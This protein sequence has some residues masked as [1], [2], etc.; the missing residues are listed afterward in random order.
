MAENPSE[1]TATRPKDF[2]EIY[3]NQI[4]YESSVW[5]LKILFS[6]LDQS[7]PAAVTRTRAA[8]T[9]PWAQVKLMLYF[10]QVQLWAHEV[11]H[12]PVAVPRQVRPEDLD[13]PTEASPEIQEVF[14]RAKQLSAEIF[15]PPQ[16]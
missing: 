11:D 16:K 5:D 10:L 6:I 3:S 2:P 12:G 15:G 9:V 13:I 8:V 14:K 1:T 4:F 7:G